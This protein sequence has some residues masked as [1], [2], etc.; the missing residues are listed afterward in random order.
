MA[1]WPGVNNASSRITISI[2]SAMQ[3]KDVRIFAPI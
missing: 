2:I 3:S 1:S